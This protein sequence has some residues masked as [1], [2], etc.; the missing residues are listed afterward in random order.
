MKVIFSW[1][2]VLDKLEPK[3]SSTFDNIEGENWLDC[4]LVDDGGLSIDIIIPWMEKCLDKIQ[5]IKAGEITNYNWDCEAFGA[6]L[7]KNEVKILSLYDEKYFQVIS[8]DL[9]SK[10]MQEWIVFLKEGPCINKTKV[11][12]LEN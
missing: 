2:N 4:L 8:L 10:I 3:C 9:F 1:E 11:L 5:Q 12:I 6:E 7:C